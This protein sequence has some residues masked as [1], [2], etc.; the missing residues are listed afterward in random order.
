MDKNIAVQSLMTLC[1]HSVGLDQDVE[2][3]RKM[4][5]EHGVHHLPVLEGG[6]L[7]GIISD[8]DIK[9]ASGWEDAKDSSFTVKD[10]YIP[11]PYIVT[12]ETKLEVV[13]RRMVQD[14]IGCVLVAIHTDK[15]VGI[16]TTTDACRY[17]AEILESK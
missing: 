17:L 2:I 1:P 8:R 12:P 13:L 11:E 16:F 9:F 3:A 10:V 15:L 7:I 14:Q 4:M 6:R 5:Q